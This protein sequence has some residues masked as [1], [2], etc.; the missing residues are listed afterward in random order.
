[1]RRQPTFSFAEPEDEDLLRE[2]I[3]YVADKCQGDRKFGA[4]KLNKIL[5]WSDFLAYAEH[6][7]PITG[8]PYMR[9]G[10]GPAPK[11]LLP[12][13]AEM[14][15][16]RDI[17]IAKV[18][19]LGGYVQKRVVP[20]RAADLSV[21]EARQI[22]LVDEVISALWRKTAKGVSSLSHGKAWKVAS[23]KDP[24]PYEAVFLSNARVNRYDTARTKQLAREH[25][26]A[27]A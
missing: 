13:R 10:N 20:L 19:A 9:L 17:A 14:L 15:D 22:A 21:F 27:L 18:P 12:V 16:A 11:K 23:D 2:L 25:D 7:K 4:T 3:I 24:I 5:W 6:G 26:W 1:M 8:T